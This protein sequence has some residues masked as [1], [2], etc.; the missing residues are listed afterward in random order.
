[1]LLFPLLEPALLFSDPGALPVPGPDVFLSLADC[2]AAARPDNGLSALSGFG[3]AGGGGGGGPPPTTEG[4]GGG[5]GG[6]A[7][8]AGGAAGG[9]G[10]AGG[11]AGGVGGWGAEL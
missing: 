5:A 6:A 8:G 10:G 7:G 9:A 2:R 11:A 4:A 1:M 3:G